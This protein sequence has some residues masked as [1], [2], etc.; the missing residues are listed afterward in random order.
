MKEDHTKY[1]NIHPSEKVTLNG[2][3]YNIDKKLVP[4]IKELNKLGLKTTQCCEGGSVQYVS[5]P[6]DGVSDIHSMAYISLSLENIGDVAIRE[7]GKRLV[8][9]WKIK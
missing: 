1:Q 3:T 5:C 2:T 9:W 4:L 8:I 6:E 7:N